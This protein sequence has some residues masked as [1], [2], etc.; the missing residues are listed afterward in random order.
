MLAARLAQRGYRVLGYATGA[1]QPDAPGAGI[2]Q[3]ATA[4]YLT[5]ASDVVLLAIATLDGARAAL[6]GPEGVFSALAPGQVVIDV[7]SSSPSAAQRWATLAR[8]RAGWYLDVPLC[9]AGEDLYAPAGGDQAAYE[10]A[11]PVLR[12][13]ASQVAHVGPSG[14]GATARLLVQI[15]AG[16]FAAARDEG[17][18][19][20]HHIGVD[21]EAVTTMMPGLLGVGGSITGI[22]GEPA[23]LADFGHA[24]DLAQELRVPTPITALLNEHFKRRLAQQ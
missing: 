3:V 2:E 9:Q 24:L 4:F 15:I 11:Q 20:A 1:E 12:A 6:E 13:I 22:G 19:L 17:L 18:V 10:V 5:S 23:A 21:V 7:C 8:E 14:A 16:A